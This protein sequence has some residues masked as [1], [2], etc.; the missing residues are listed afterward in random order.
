MIDSNIRRGSYVK[1]NISEWDNTL[2]GYGRVDSVKGNRLDIVDFKGHSIYID[3]RDAQKISALAYRGAVRRLL[4]QLNPGGFWNYKG[5]PP[6]DLDP[7][8]YVVTDEDLQKGFN[9]IISE[10]FRRGIEPA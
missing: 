5:V 1:F 6:I 4:F 10:M 7:E 2:F 3:R 8:P 9:N